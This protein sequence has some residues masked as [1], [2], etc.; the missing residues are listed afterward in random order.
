MNRSSFLT[1]HWTVVLAAGD[2]DSTRARDALATLCRT[3]WYPLYAYVRRRGHRPADAEDLTQG[4]F[5]RLLELHSLADVRRERGRFRAFLLASLNHYLADEW[6]HAS[7]G[8]RDIRRTIPLDAGAAETRYAQE[9]ADH[10]TPEHLFERQWAL[11][12][13]ETVVHRLQ[14][15]YTSAGKADLFMTLRFAIT[16][17]GNN[18]PYADLAQV[19]GMTEPAVRVA[20]HRLRKRYRELL[21]DQIAQTVTSPDQVEEEL[22]S[23]FQSLGGPA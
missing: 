5:A 15:E 8:K 16:G 14:S 12:L 7:A 11:T 10:Q 22:H 20:V 13:L 9:P 18:Q 3:Y 19:I 21:R 6:D 2:G 4:F 1:T 17:Q 23:L